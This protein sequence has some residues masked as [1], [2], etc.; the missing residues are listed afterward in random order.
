MFTTNGH[1]YMDQAHRK[2]PSA[3]P[4]F[5]SK[6]RIQFHTRTFHNNATPTKGHQRRKCPTLP[7]H[8][9]NKEGVHMVLIQE[10]VL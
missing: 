6:I 2:R 10:A 7:L 3:I 8:A 1:V 5:R 4:K 9:P